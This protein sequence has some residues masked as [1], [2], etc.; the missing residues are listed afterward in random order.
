MASNSST[1]SP[2]VGRAHADPDPSAST[3]AD[4]EENLVFQRA[5]LASL[6]DLPVTDVTKQQIGEIKFEIAS[7]QK[8]LAEARRAVTQGTS[9]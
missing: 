4:L 2:A 8:R 1:A 5:A 7:T 6:R 9:G 3:I